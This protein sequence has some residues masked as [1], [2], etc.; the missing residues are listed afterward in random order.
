MTEPS[1]VLERVN[2]HYA[3]VAFAERSLKALLARAMRA[4]PTRVAV[5]DIH[6]LKDVSV[7]IGPG[8]RVGVIGHN[9]AGKSTLLRA[10]AGL[11]PLSGGELCVRGK[12]RAMFELG[13]GFEPDATGR[14]N[15]LY[16]GLLLGLTPAEVR[17]REQEVIAFA[18]LGEFIDYPI[19]TYSAGMMVRLAFAITT[20]VGGEVLLIDEVIGAGDAA[21]MTKAR[22]RIDEVIAGSQILLLSSHDFSSLLRLCRRGLVLHHGQ[23]VF[24]GPIE[25][26]IAHYREINGIS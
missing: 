2:L 10:I 20:C 12:V 16:R 1:I 7:S 5:H 19:R 26:A 11:Y 21:F 3:S 8:E 24:D 14:E 6:A 9:G 4:R 22:R 17:S 25:P 23:L 15:I 18:E 13:L